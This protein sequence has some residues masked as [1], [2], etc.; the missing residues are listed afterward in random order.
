MSGPAVA[1][2]QRPVVPVAA[3]RLEGRHDPAMRDREALG[4]GERRRARELPEHLALARARDLD[5]VEV[6]SD[7]LVVAREQLEP[8]DRVVDDVER[9]LL[10]GS[11]NDSVTRACR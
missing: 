4:I 6:R 11:Q 3:E 2:A 8:L 10:H 5:L 7:R 1:A 9:T